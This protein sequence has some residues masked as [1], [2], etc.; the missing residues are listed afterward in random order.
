VLVLRGRIQHPLDHF[1]E[2]VI[3]H[4]TYVRGKRPLEIGCIAVNPNRWA[5]F[6]RHS[7]DLK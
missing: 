7:M 4:R 2:V 5:V 6:A 1:S 3:I